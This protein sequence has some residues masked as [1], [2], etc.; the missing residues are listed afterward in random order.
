MPW[1]SSESDA[2]ATMRHEGPET[3]STR[4]EDARRRMMA[5]GPPS[6]G[7]DLL[8]MEIDFEAYLP[9]CSALQSVR[10]THTGNPESL[11]VAE[12][13]AHSAASP[14]AVVEQLRRTWQEDLSYRYCE[15][16]RIR[17]SQ[18]AVHLDVVTQIGRG[19]FYVTGTIVVRWPS[20]S[21][22]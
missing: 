13:V 5:S 1:H 12:C 11:I 17:R 21:S 18:G 20:A 4:F 14:D 19:Q 9:R 10:A 6:N 8:G 22:C 16:H 3:V 2:N 15:A 7:D